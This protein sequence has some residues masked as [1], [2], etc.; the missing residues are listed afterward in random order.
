MLSISLPLTNL[1]QTLR[2]MTL[3]FTPRSPC[4]L[5]RFKA[6]V[7]DPDA[8]NPELACNL[9]QWD[10]KQSQL[11]KTWGGGG[12]SRSVWWMSLEAKVDPEL[13]KTLFLL[14]LL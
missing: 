8:M 11:G 10:K 5:D 4:Q 13:T 9:G 7:S 6:K 12:I 14:L 1:K 2:V 3:N